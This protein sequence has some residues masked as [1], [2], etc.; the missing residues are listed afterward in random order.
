MASQA[1]INEAL[2]ILGIKLTDFSSNLERMAAD[3]RTA[4]FVMAAQLGKLNRTEEAAP[5]K[6]TRKKTLEVFQT[7]QEL[8]LE[9][10]RNISD[11][12][13]N[14]DMLDIMVEQAKIHD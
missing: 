13:Q 5:P 7:Q 2:P 8:S 1:V 6:L 14:R 10:M 11:A 9:Q 4:E 12:N 3:P